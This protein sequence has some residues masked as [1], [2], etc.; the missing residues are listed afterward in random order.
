MASSSAVQGDFQASTMAENHQHISS[1]GLQNHLTDQH[2][3]TFKDSFPNNRSID[4]SNPLF[5]NSGENP[6]LILVGSPLTGENYNT[7]SRSMLVSLSA[8]NKIG[9]V[10]GSI[11]EPPEHDDLFPAWTRCN[12]MVVS[13]ILHVV[14]SDI[15]SSIIYITSSKIMWEDL[16]DRYSQRNGPRIFQLQKSIAATFQENSNVSQY[17][18]QLKTL[19]EEL[20]NYSPMSICN[21]CNCGRVKSILEFHSQERVYQFLMG[22]NDSFSAVR[23]QILL[24]DPLPP[25][26]KVFSLIIQEEKQREISVNSMSH[27]SAALLTKSV[28]NPSSS[29]MN[30]PTALM[31]KSNLGSRFAKPNFRKPICSH[32][33]LSGHTIEKCYKV[34][35][36]PPRFKFTK[37]K[38]QNQYSSSQH[39]AN[40]IQSSNQ[41][42]SPQ[43]SANQVQTQQPHPH[44]LNNSHS[45]SNPPQLS[46]ISAQCQHLMEMLKQ[47]PTTSQPANAS[48]IGNSGYN[49]T[50]NPRYSVFSTF[51]NIAAHSNQKTNPLILDTG[52]TDHM[53]S[54]SSLFTTITAIV[55]TH[56]NLPN[57]AKASVTHIGTIKLSDNLTLTEVL[58]VP[59][60]SFN[61]ISASKL[62]KNLHCCLIFLAGYCF[63]QSLHHWRTIG[64]A[65]E[66]AGLFYLLPENEVSSNASESVPSFH[67]HVS[68]NSIKE[69]SCDLWHYRLGHPSNSRIRLIQSIVPAISCKQNE[70]CSICP[71]AKQHKLPFPV[72]VSVSEFP[73][74]LLHCDIWGPMATSSINGS[75][76]FLTIVD[77]CTRFT[78][79]HLMQHKSQTA[80]IIHSFSNMV[81]TQFKT[82]IKCIRSDNGSEF[83][84]KDFFSTQGIIHQLSCVETPQQNAIVERKHQH[85]LNVARSLRFQSHLPLQFWSDCILSAAHIINRIPTPLFSNKSSYQLL[86]SKVPSYSHL[87]V[88]GCLAYVSTLS[89]NRTKFDP[90]ATPCIFIGYPHNMK[91]YKFYNLQNQSV[92]ISRNAIFHETIFPYATHIDHSSS[93]APNIDN[94]S[95]ILPD[96]DYIHSDSPIIPSLPITLSQTQ[97]PSA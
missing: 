7:W 17:F 90:R 67:K 66:K 11:C 15:K 21:C 79:V 23:A 30:E 22:L 80:S 57:G 65:K 16:K 78:W 91:G 60:F 73:F 96:T 33:G 85:L 72:S 40:Q 25:L 8:K 82:K 14:S 39:L 47:F 43:Y 86:F 89:R 81:Q 52:A 64:V 74:D 34:H 54:C 38:P 18:T 6:A 2:Q 97:I 31:T 13:W 48:A 59:S 44:H 35:G 62:L 84:M 41:Y 53:I 36:F 28:L 50:L 88:F 27:E 63:I 76:L 61:L 77:D 87:K 19:W 46:V 9:F 56:V 20:N 51:V 42:S 4:P 26:N 1:N 55:S 71:L 75:K 45:M 3:N 49:S 69:P 83:H 70:I 58:C 93:P 29:Q 92:I 37:T 10:N 68:F 32:C 95:S 94:S 5:L 24:T 12:D